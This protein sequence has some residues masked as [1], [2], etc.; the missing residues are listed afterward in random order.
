MTDFVRTTGGLLQLRKKRVS[1]TDLARI[2]EFA[3]KLS[4]AGLTVHA[5][6]PQ[7]FGQKHHFLKQTIADERTEV[8]PVDLQA[9]L[10]AV[11]SRP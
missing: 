3:Q 1:Q 7:V 10:P 6:Q 5:H 2:A 11:F 8:E 4:D 9:A